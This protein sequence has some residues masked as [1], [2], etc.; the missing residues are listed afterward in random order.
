MT[1][2]SPLVVPGGVDG[3]KIEI[4]WHSIPITL[5]TPTVDNG[6]TLVPGGVNGFKREI[7]WHSIPITL[8][9]QSVENGLTLVPGGVDGFKRGIGWN[10]IP[11]ILFIPSVSSIISIRVGLLAS[12]F[13][14]TSTEQKHHNIIKIEDLLYNLFELCGSSKSYVDFFEG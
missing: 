7:G 9:T 14:A 2:D 13:L 5:L 4:G 3:L 6:L 1:V 8:L 12:Q 10:S 11:I